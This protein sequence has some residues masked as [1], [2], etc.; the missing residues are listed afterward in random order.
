[1]TTPEASGLSASYRS[2]ILFMTLGTLIAPGMDAVAKHLGDSLSPLVITWGRFAFQSVLMLGLLMVSGGLRALYT[3]RFGLHL[4]RGA[5]LAT[6]TLLFFW[7]LQQLPLAECIAIFF[8]Q[9]MILTLLSWWFLGETVGVHR[10]LA[11]VTGFIGALIIIQP[12][13]TQ[14]SFFYLLPLGAALF[15][16]IYLAVTRAFARVDTPAVQQMASGLGGTL[17]LSALL[18]IAELFPNT[19]AWQQP[20]NIEWAWLFSIG[21]VAAV[22][23]TLVVMGMSRAPASVLAPFGYSEII[24]ATLL[25][26]WIF[27]DWPHPLT[28]LGVLLIVAAGGYVAWRETQ[29]RAVVT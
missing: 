29:Q 19:W 26:W 16:A 23:H 5:L 27:G 25:G 7:A 4:V 28:W 15:Y 13:G 6:A 10:K 22:A 21:L 11:V 8:V 2:G 9:P 1:M 17:F 18:G 14:F 24:A 12:G 20:T 3:H